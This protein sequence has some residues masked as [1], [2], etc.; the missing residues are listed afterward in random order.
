MGKILV[1]AEKP[2]V[3]R[4]LARVLGCT[5]SRDGH[6]IG[7]KYIVTWS[8]GHLVTLADPE[9]YGAQYQKWSL[10]TLPM[11][12]E[13]MDLVVIKETGRQFQ[14]VKNLMKNPEVSELIIATDAGREGELV[15]RWIMK[16]VGFSKPVKRLW[17]SSQTD[18]SMKE[19]FAQLKPAAAYD[20][21]YASAQS[22][23]EAD[24]LVGLNVTRALTCKHNAQL[25]AGRVQTPTLSMVV[26]RENEIKKF[27]PKTF[28]TIRADFA[29]FRAL[30]KDAKTGQN[31]L[32]DQKQ[33]NEIKEKALGKEAVVTDLQ[34]KAKKD[35]PPLLYDLTELQRE[36]NIRF[37]FSAKKTLNLIQSLYEEHKVL[38]YPRT[39]SR[40][41][42]RDLVPSFKDRLK[43]ISASGYSDAVGEILKKGRSMSSRM[44]DDGKVTD[45]HAIIP[46]EE[47]V[48][49]GN[50][51]FEERKIYDL[52]AKRFLAAFM[53]DYESLITTA[54]L[55]IGGETFQTKGETVKTKGWKRIYERDGGV[56]TDG[57]EENEEDQQQLPVLS[58]KQKQKLLG[59]QVTTGQTSP[60]KRLTEAALLASMEHHNL[61]TPAT[62]AD[63]IEKLIAA[64]SIERRGKELFPLSKG[65]QLVE[66]APKELTSPELTAKWEQRL[67]GIS[68][69]EEKS[70]VFLTE[71]RDFTKTLVSRVIASDGTYRHDNMTRS[72]CPMCDKFLL[73][74]NGK[75]GKMLVCQDRECGYRQSLSYLSNARCPECH[76]KLQVIGEGEKRLYSCSCGFREKFQRFND[77]LKEKRNQMGGRE[78]KDYMKKIEEENKGESAFALAWAKLQ[79]EKKGK[80]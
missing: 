14:V 34:Q 26:E 78:L 6:M 68:K 70:K 76:K 54:V 73:E 21:L 62:R 56:F 75:K 48:Q 38:T 3:G 43:A 69:G 67:N 18:K 80:K 28:Y 16:K 71:M 12:P 44:V 23:A 11:L 40:Y 52:V 27:T 79:E 55:T 72:R 1:L 74:I 17:I 35:K 22:R 5:Q 41:L 39:D 50:L 46:T 32:F 63:I 37:G 24:W 15:A 20:N 36:A 10:D 49:S 45:H 60:P 4:E 7:A 77:Q 19:G 61:G 66:L 33:A 59:C 29:G 13:R 64:N 65:S 47:F 30:W 2:S 8:L 57:E 53:E 58:L 51:S 42:S 25:S 9:H 31:R